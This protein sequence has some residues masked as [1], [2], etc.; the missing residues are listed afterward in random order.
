MYVISL[1]LAL[2]ALP[3]EDRFECCKINNKVYQPHRAGLKIVRQ[4]I[5][6]SSNSL[7]KGNQL[8]NT[9]TTS[10]PTQGDF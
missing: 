7:Q 4:P 9:Y 5:C 3:E 8:S 6:S 1:Y 2:S 10:F